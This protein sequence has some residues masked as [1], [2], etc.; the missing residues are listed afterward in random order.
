MK[1]SIGN[2]LKSYLLGSMLCNSEEI[3]MSNP[4]NNSLETLEG[5]QMEDISQYIDGVSNGL[6]R[7]LKKLDLP[8]DRVL[9]DNIERSKAIFLLPG[10]LSKLDTKARER[11]LYISKFIAACG[12]GLFDAA[13]N[14]LWDE[15]ILNLREKVIRYDLDYFYNSIRG[16]DRTKYIND[17]DLMNLP[18]WQLIE[19]CRETEIITIMGYRHLNYIRDMRNFASA[20]HPN[21]IELTGL[22]LVDWLEICIKEVLAKE[23]SDS[24][25]VI[26]KL[27]TNIREEVFDESVA[28]HIRSKIESLPTEMSGTLLKSLFGM[29]TDKRFSPT[30]RDNIDLIA[31]NIWMQTD[32]PIKQY[33]GSLYAQYVYNG[34][35]ARKG[36]A[37]N[38]LTNVDG[39]GYLT[40]DIKSVEIG[41]VLSLLLN[42][43]REYYNF[44]NEEPHAKNLFRYIHEMRDIPQSIRYEYVKTLILCRLGNMHGVAHTAQPY[45][46]EMIKMFQDDCIKEFLRLLND[47]EVLANL[48]VTRY[49]IFLSIA[50]NFSQRTTNAIVKKGLEV[51]MK[52]KMSEITQKKTY[53]MISPLLT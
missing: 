21:Q 44:Y 9:V 42:S 3:C 28:C 40:E 14:Y 51:L 37:S 8:V 50:D 27:I 18:D 20:A 47:D 31:R 32:E 35:V 33:I 22:N 39:L 36:F 49:R 46:D 38:F 17:D 15:T 25:I 24:A 12:A 52:S 2:A 34:D 6:I 30:V 53:K 13:L 16:L 19:G 43:H 45:Y 11:A 1:A 23:P 10:T 7:Y 29:Y 26:K 5:W 41:N 4:G 48:D